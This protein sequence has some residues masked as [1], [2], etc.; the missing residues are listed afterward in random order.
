MKF[1]CFISSKN[2][3]LLCFCKSYINYTENFCKKLIFSD[4]FRLN[5]SAAVRRIRWLPFL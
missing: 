2:S 1:T 3:D 5:L 4:N